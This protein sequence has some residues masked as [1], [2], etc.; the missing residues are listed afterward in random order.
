MVVPTAPVNG[1]RRWAQGVVRDSIHDDDAVVDAAYDVLLSAV[2]ADSVARLEAFAAVAS[3]REV[4]VAAVGVAGRA[5]VPVHLLVYSHESD[6]PVDLLDICG[7]RLD[8]PLDPPRI[9]YPEVK[10]SEVMRVT[11]VDRDDVGVAWVTVVLARRSERADTVLTWR[12]TDLV[13]LSA[14]SEL[15]DG[16]LTGVVIDGMTT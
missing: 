15:L 6:S 14:M 11:R 9:E 7:V 4:V 16:L 8:S 3:S 13:L 5:P 12:S 2:A 1:W 10:G